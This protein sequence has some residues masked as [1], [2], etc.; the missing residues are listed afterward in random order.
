MAD[1]AIQN[2]KSQIE[3]IQIQLS[4]LNNIISNI[5]DKSIRMIPLIF[6]GIILYI[7]TTYGNIKI[8]NVLLSI[9]LIIFILYLS[10]IYMST[11]T[12]LI[13][14]QSSMI[15][16]LVLAGIGGS[17]IEYNIFNNF[18]FINELVAYLKSS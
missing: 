11:G 18:S 4:N 17:S 9:I 10:F 13:G 14:I 12:I 6:I 8:I 15:Q 3:Q 5:S 1:Q 16:G 2:I 7:K